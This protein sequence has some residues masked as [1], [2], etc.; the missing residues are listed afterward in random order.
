MSE[1][2]CSK[3]GRPCVGAGVAAAAPEEE[4][5]QQRARSIKAVIAQRSGRNP[6]ELCHVYQGVL[7]GRERGRQG[8][9]SCCFFQISDELMN[10]VG[11]ARCN[12]WAV[13]KRPVTSL[14]S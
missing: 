3:I 13:H 9:D 10:A 11:K 5:C 1:D 4:K 8:N 14:S 12:I 7:G 2:L 6:E